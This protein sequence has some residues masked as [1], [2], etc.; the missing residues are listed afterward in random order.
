MKEFAKK[1][2]KWLAITKLMAFPRKIVAKV[3]FYV[4]SSKNGVLIFPNDPERLKVIALSKTINQE[5]GLAVSSN[6]AY[7]IFMVVKRTAKI[8]GDIAEVGVWKGGSAKLICEAKG[9][10]ALHLFDTFEG[11]PDLCEIDDPKQFQKGQALW[12][13]ENVKTYLKKY[14]NVFFY[15]GLFPSTAEPIKNKRFSFVNLDVDLYK[16]TLNCLEFFYSKMNTGG[17][18]ISHDYIG[19]P[20]VRKA[21][22][23]FFEEK[24]EP[25][26]ELADSQCLIV[27]C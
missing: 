10:K 24:P 18:I 8:N 16:S 20:G 4:I 19:A 14:P 5:Q 13:V 22:D 9:N 26:I 3:V 6:E 12:D 17:V 15:K 27:K 1:I 23:D 7:Q 11:L 25:I 21:V 2:V